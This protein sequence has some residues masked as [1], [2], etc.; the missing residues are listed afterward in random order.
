MPAARE[1]SGATEP[2]KSLLGTVPGP[3][4]GVEAALLCGDPGPGNAPWVALPTMPAR[5]RTPMAIP[6]SFIQELLARADV[7]DIVGRYV[8]LKKGGANYMGLCPF[9]GEKSPSFSVSPTKQFF[10]CFG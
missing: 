8:Q 6:Q 7:V 1:R 2:V 10:H 9:H 4:G 3:M 5:T